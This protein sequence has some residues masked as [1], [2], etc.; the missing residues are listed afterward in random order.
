MYFNTTNT[1]TLVSYT[2]INRQ[3]SKCMQY[4]KDGDIKIHMKN[5]HPEGKFGQTEFESNFIFEK[6]ELNCKFTYT[7]SKLRTYMYMYMYVYR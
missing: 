1:M 3:K 7:L 2:V 6:Y 4:C 5:M